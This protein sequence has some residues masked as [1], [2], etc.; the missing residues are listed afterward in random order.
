MIGSKTLNILDEGL[1]CS[2]STEKQESNKHL[3]VSLGT[4]AWLKWL[5]TFLANIRPRI[6]SPVLPKKER[7]KNKITLRTLCK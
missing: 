6:Q 7:K 1:C 2:D 5:T 3:K 4:G